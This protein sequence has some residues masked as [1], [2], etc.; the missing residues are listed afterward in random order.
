MK[1]IILFLGIICILLAGCGKKDKQVRLLITTWEKD[2]ESVYMRAHVKRFEELHPN[3]KV[4]VED[5]VPW[6]RML[7]KLMITTAG[8][9]SPDVARIS[10]EWFIPLAAKHVLVP[11]NDLIEKDNFDIGDFY[12]TA[13]DSCTYDGTLYCL[14]VALDAYG[15]YYNKKMFDDAGVPYPDDTWTY[16]DFV[17]ACQKIGGDYD[18]DGRQDHWGAALWPWNT[19]LLAFDG[20]VLTPDHSK[21]AVTSEN[22]IAGFQFMVD[23]IHKYRACPTNEDSA[24]FDKFRLFTS[25][26]VAMTAG[27]CWWG[28]TCTREAPTIDFDVAPMPKGPRGT[29]ATT[30]AS[31][32][33]AV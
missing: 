5:C 30:L 19:Y 31:D 24:N 2:E 16:D 20:D 27:G 26:K 21:C 4:D 1:K 22:G 23:L 25:G 14:P 32:S 11:L 10:S 8:H 12:E 3:I 29:R 9:R 28:D 7:S 33:F 13:L 15:I 17:K 18:G 6:N